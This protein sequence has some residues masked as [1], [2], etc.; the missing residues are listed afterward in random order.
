MITVEGIENSSHNSEMRIHCRHKSFI[1]Y[2]PNPDD[3]KYWIKALRASIEGTHAEENNTKTIHKQAKEMTKEETQEFDDISSSG[4]D[5]PVPTVVV[6]QNKEKKKKTTKADPNQT[7]SPRAVDQQTFATT[8]PF[9]SST[10]PSPF[11]TV[12]PFTTNTAPLFAPTATPTPAPAP[13]SAPAATPFLGGAP[14]SPN[15]FLTNTTP[16]AT[17]PILFNNTAQ[18]AGNLFAP[19]PDFSSLLTLDNTGNLFAAP[20]FAPTPTLQPTPAMATQTPFGASFT[21]APATVTPFGTTTFGAQTTVV[22]TTAQPTPFGTTS[23][24]TT[25]FGA[26]ATSSNPFATNTANSNPFLKS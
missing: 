13:A 22:T 14:G 16:F 20:T 2:V 19:T 25:T 7:L 10:G 15:P 18:P 24:G 9:A 5:A 21:P 1:C 26:S 17:Q 4:E 11:A 8:N 6:N 12:N 23:F 3:K